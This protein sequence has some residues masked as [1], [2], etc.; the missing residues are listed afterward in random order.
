VLYFIQWQNVSFLRKTEEIVGMELKTG[1]FESTLDDKG[2][3]SIPIRLRETYA[4]S[5]LVITQGRQHC[6]WVMTPHVWEFVCEKLKNAAANTEEEAALL[7]YLHIMPAQVV[8]I[9]KSGRIPVPQA[10][11]KYAKLVKDCLVLSA[12]NRLEIWDAEFFYSYL[13][14]NRPSIQEA[15]NKMGSVRLF[16]MK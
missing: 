10:I 8:E 5:E 7:E 11:R 4:G 12:E 6:A 9:D 14:D 1:T 2:R 13:E 3:V 15:W 16:S